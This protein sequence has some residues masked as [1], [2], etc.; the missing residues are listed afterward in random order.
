MQTKQEKENCHFIGKGYSLR[1]IKVL[2]V[3][4]ENNN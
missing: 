3:I 2:E 1:K 4:L